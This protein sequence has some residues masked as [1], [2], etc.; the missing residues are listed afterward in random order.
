[1]QIH[2]TP[3]TLMTEGG[4]KAIREH[5]KIVGCKTSFRTR[6]EARSFVR[7]L[8]WTE[9]FP[10]NEDQQKV[11]GSE[12]QVENVVQGV[13][14]SGKTTMMIGLF[15]RRVLFGDLS[16]DKV[17]F[18]AFNVSIRNELRKK[19][20]VL[21]TRPMVRTFDSMIYEVCARHG[22]EGLDKPDYEGR[23]RFVERLRGDGEKME[24]WQKIRL[25]LVD[26][27]QDLDRAAFDFFKTFFPNAR[28]YFFGDVFQC[29]QKEPRSSMLWHLL[30]PV[31][32]RQI[33]FM[34][35]TPRVPT[36]ILSTIQ[37]ALVHHYPEYETPIRG[38]YSSNPLPASDTRIEWAPI[39]HYSQIF[40]E[41]TRFLAEHP[42]NE[43]MIL[44]FSS[45]IT[46][47][48]NM[49]D[50]SRFR[51][52]LVREK[53]PVNRNYKSMENDR[54]FLSTVNSS[55]GLERPY[56]FIALTFPLE[57]AFANFSNDLV[58]NLISVGLSRCKVRVRFCVPVY[59]DR[60]SR[61]LHLYPDCPTPIE[62]AKT[63]YKKAPATSVVD[64]AV[65]ASENTTI[66][67]YLTRSHSATEILRQGILSYGTRSLLRSTARYSPDAPSFPAGERIRFGMRGEEEASFVG[68]LFEVLI[69]SLWTGR[70][71]YL[72]VG[73]MQQVT[74]NPMYTHCRHGID[75]HFQKLVA[76]FRLPYTTASF[77]HR[78]DAL[79]LYTGYHILVSQK[80][81]VNVPVERREDMKRAWSTLWKDL[82]RLRPDPP[83]L[84]TLKPQ[85][86]LSRPFQTGIADLFREDDKEAVIYEIKTCSGSDWKEDAFTQAALYMAMSKR[87]RGSIRLLNPFRREIMEYNMTL[88][89]KTDILLQIDREM[90]LWNLN[91]YLA[92]YEDEKSSQPI[93][94]IVGCVCTVG[95]M[96]LEWMAPTRTR[97][98]LFTTDADYTDRRIFRLD[99]KEPVLA[100][101]VGLEEITTT[102]VMIQRMLQRIRFETPEDTKTIIDW[103][104]P[105]SQCV[106]LASFLRHHY[107]LR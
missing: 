76:A 16:P 5:L 50:L 73:G 102:D 40:E 106:L 90:L 55:K 25:V 46:V 4:L 80:I 44:T 6:E 99:S 71:P 45:A 103:K 24:E 59:A 63:A 52:F 92:K 69:T 95:G 56:V 57:L 42:P 9:T 10:W 77:Q 72:D 3:Q 70:W 23:R 15:M 11:L 64:Q 54:L 104:D 51:Q 26:E 37:N 48:G 21:K 19:T 35:R 101:M 98:G 29:I 31:E 39:R 83:I 28:F 100:D 65:T 43:C 97:I 27:V 81:R 68:V 88:F 78:F 105:F 32:G 62:D 84:S 33:H 82:E 87:L 8:Y 14:G 13:F 1:M 38:W 74:G 60:F 94:D 58:V 36:N 86:S 67:D 75:G 93:L 49:G 85:V 61:V 22:M 41:A 91:C 20:R 34:K 66:G 30:R 79:F 107:R 53:V 12:E 2:D 17:L 18:C 47:K 7:S 96:F 89:S